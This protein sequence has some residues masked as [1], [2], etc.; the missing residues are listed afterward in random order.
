VWDASY[1]AAFAE[2][3]AT[4]TRD[5]RE[6]AK[7]SNEQLFRTRTQGALKST[8]KHIAEA[9]SNLRSLTPTMDGLLVHS[10]F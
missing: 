3:D 1:D 8:M 7:L 2:A 6:A 9:D 5:A 10:D 4:G